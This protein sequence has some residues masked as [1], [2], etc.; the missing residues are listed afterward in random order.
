ME[1]Y[2]GESDSGSET[3]T[4]RSLS[5]SL[6][7]GTSTSVTPSPRCET[8]SV[9]GRPRKS[10][11]WDYFVYNSSTQKS[12]CQVSASSGGDDSA[13]SPG[14][15]VC[16]HALS[17]KFATNLKQHLKKAHPPLY[18]AVLAK[19]EVMAK[20]RMKKPKKITGPSRSQLTIGETLQRKYDVTSNRCQLLTQKLAVFI[21]S[22]CVPNSLVES[23][24]F[25]SLLEALDPRYP[26][27]GR[28]RIEKEIDK[29]LV[30]MR[31]KIQEYLSKVQKVS[32]CAD[33]WTKKGMSSSYLGI[34]AH[35]FSS[36]DHR[37]HRVTLA[38]RRIPHPHTA[39]NIRRIV[40]E[41]LREWKIPVCN[42]MAILTDNAS[43]MVKAFRQEV[44]DTLCEDDTTDESD[45]E[46]DDVC[47]DEDFETRERNHDRTFQFF[48]KRLS[49]FAH[50]LQLV[51]HKFSENR[52]LCET[53]KRVQAVVKK[54]NRSSKAT[55][56]LL[57]QCGKKLVGSCPTR[58]SS[59]YLVIERVLAV[60]VSLTRVLEELEWDNLAT[61]E[62][63]TLE[64]ILKLLK[65]F[66]QYT[67]LSSGEDYSTLSSVI[68]IIMELNLH[69]EDMKK[70]SELRDVCV[71]LQS[72]LKH[73][74]RKCTDPS[75]PN[76][77]PLFLIAAMLDPRYKILL[78]PI[79][80]Q[81]AKKEL[82]IELKEAAGNNGSSGSSGD[83]A[84][85]AHPAEELEEP[86]PKRFCH[87]SRLLEEKVKEGIQKEAKAPPGQQQLEQYVQTVH[88]LPEDFD[89]LQFWIENEATYPLLATV[90][91]DVLAI[92]GSSAP[93][94]RVFSTA[95]ESTSG[96]RNR[97]ADKNLEREVLL[98][99][100]KDYLFS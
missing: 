39:E 62:W 57:A 87:L 9:I 63:K 4:P 7:P 49:C 59:S 1:A 89:P 61:S 16:G 69:L 52:I 55:E 56:M 65:P 92:P 31:S 25:R 82:L 96:R 34:T 100:N 46:S 15:R 75:D 27:P 20:E 23:S 45:Q 28:T 80:T 44:E 43:N 53:M 97:L 37:R 76:H 99:K 74:F 18:L 73:R 94:E 50:T 95:G 68:P 72:E 81:A 51:V 64:N 79:Q 71:T 90:A 86:R 19:E 13:E 12:V 70:V 41:V 33:V 10:P 84:S 88:Q 24:E 3:V 26:V 98:R 30:D 21:G 5:P 32:L 42:V 66:A 22:T 17:G 14:S 38:V 8:R 47:A 58:W 29:V 35:F 67:A 91:V 40:D 78:N 77:E 85:P 54:V 6:S 2:S 11:V 93:V 48:C 60:R 83:G 36:L